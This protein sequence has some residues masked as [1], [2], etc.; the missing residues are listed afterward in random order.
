MVWRQN[1]GGMPNGR[2][3]FR[4]FN[5]MPGLSDIIGILPDGRFFACEIKL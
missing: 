1:Q 5:G 4:R 2:G 3:G